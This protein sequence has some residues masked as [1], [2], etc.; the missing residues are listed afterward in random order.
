MNA[1]YNLLRTGRLQRYLS[2]DPFPPPS[3]ATT[4][5]ARFQHEGN[6]EELLMALCEQLGAKPA[7]TAPSSKPIPE[8]NE[9]GQ[10]QGQDGPLV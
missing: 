7:L 5:S 4:L 6:L 9:R 10:K 3:A 8:G 2:C 1:T